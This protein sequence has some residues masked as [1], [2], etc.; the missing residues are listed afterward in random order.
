MFRRERLVPD[1]GRPITPLS[2]APAEPEEMLSSTNGYGN[3]LIMG[4]RRV[5]S[6]TFSARTV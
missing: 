3:M 1:S 4:K 6:K 5:K 2:G